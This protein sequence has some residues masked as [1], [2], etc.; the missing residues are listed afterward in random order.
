[1]TSTPQTLK[2]STSLL[3]LVADRAQLEFQLVVFILLMLLLPL[4]LLVSYLG[5]LWTCYYCLLL[6]LSGVSWLVG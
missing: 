6:F 1:M 5:C 2:L 4:L 3:L